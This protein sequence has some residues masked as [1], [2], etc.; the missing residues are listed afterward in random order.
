MDMAR[1][2]FA[3]VIAVN[4]EGAFAVS[5]AVA[6]RMA[7]TGQ[8]G[9]IVNIGSF[10]YDRAMRNVASYAASKA[11]LHQVTRSLAL[12]WSR[13]AI[14]VNEI[15][16]GWFPTEMTEPFL[17]GRAGAILAQTNPLRRLGGA[18][19]IAGAA[20]LLCSDAGAYMTGAS[21]AID[22]GQSLV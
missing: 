1:A 18:T 5:Q 4:V 9:S 7:D 17:G 14:R 20:L 11:A 10:L 13:H 12:E 19:D 21:I 2:D 22:G 16:P 6:R 15:M 3:R 8:G